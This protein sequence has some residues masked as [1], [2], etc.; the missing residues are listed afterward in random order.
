MKRFITTLLKNDK[1][2][3]SLDDYPE[4]QIKQRSKSERFTK[5]RAMSMG[6]DVD[7]IE[8]PHDE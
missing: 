7:T 8:T 4:R 6:F 3:G 1:L 5:E 2:F